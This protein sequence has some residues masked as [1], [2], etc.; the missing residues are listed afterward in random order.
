MAATLFAPSP[1]CVPNHYS[2]FPGRP[3]FCSM[4]SVLALPSYMA[5]YLH[6]LGGHTGVY[7]FVSAPRTVA[8][9]PR[10][11]ELQP[12]PVTVTRVGQAD[13]H[14]ARR[15]DRIKERLARQRTLEHSG[16]VA[17]LPAGETGAKQQ[18]RPPQHK[19][20]KKRKVPEAKAVIASGGSPAKRRGRI[21]PSPP[22][23]RPAPAHRV[24]AGEVE[25]WTEKLLDEAVDSLERAEAAVQTGPP[26]VT[27]RGTQTDTEVIVPTDGSQL[28][29]VALASQAVKQSIFEL[30]QEE[31]LDC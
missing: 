27:S 3:P 4:T 18:A 5:G 6:Q 31:M 8:P 21:R 28:A 9:R 22:P 1:N 15:R 16:G 25:Q 26:S 19:V 23:A 7:S 20:K 30:L 17:G 12:S 11:G 29:A 2:V 10:P 14:Y 24:S 13:Q